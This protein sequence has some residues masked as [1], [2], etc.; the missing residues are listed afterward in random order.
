MRMKD[1]S[2]PERVF[3]LSGV[4]DGN[5]RTFILQDGSNSVGR[6]PTSSILL[7]S[8]SVSHRHAIVHL[9]EGRITVRDLA[10]KNGTIVN[11]RPV[12]DAELREGDGI[13]FGSID[14]R[15]E[16]MDP[17]DTWLG[18]TSPPRV[19]VPAESPDPARTST[20]VLGGDRSELAVLRWVR[21]LEE[22]VEH[23]AL[24]SE[25]NL[26]SGLGHLTRA[27][28]ATGAALLEIIPGSASLCRAGYGS[29]SIELSAADL[30]ELA[31]EA[32]LSGGVLTRGCGRE[33]AKGTIFLASRSPGFVAV[34]FEG[35]LAPNADTRSVLGTALGLLGLCLPRG[36]SKT[37]T[38]S[39]PAEGLLF[40][41]DYVRG[42]SAAITTIYRQLESVVKSDLPILLLGETGV[43][44]ECLAGVVHSSSDRRRGPFLPVNCAAIP[45]D[46]LEA[47]L[48]GIRAGVATGVSERKGKFALADGG[49]LFLDEIGD[50][51]APLQ[52]K[53]LRAL[54][55]HVIV[56][57][58]GEEQSVDVRIVAATN[59]DIE[60]RVRDGRFR[61]DLYYRLAGLV[62]KVP[63]LRQR[64]EDIP[65]LTEYFFRQSCED[66]GKAIPGITYAAVRLLT[67]MRWPGNVRELRHRLRRLV[68]LAPE[69]CPIDTALLNRVGGDD[70]EPGPDE[71]R[72]SSGRDLS[73]WHD[74]DLSRLERRVVKEA[75]RRVGG[76]RTH[77]ARLLGISRSALRRRLGQYDL[78]QESG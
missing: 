46:L 65:A 41:E 14:L 30:D 19:T 12:P 59:T 34:I 40:P 35:L 25:P 22:L 78:E 47:E 62:L 64:T 20:L 3:A 56:P 32:E 28:G 37:G 48:F 4:V 42:H 50:M 39:E 75:L 69:G 63:P 17:E 53:L 74:L 1:S 57:V 18:I 52:A 33:G 38:G 68:Y 31:R 61:R 11:G 71:T 8:T 16:E 72:D 67:Q 5:P 60:S 66:A 2:F 27:V 51:S 21:L 44:K 49:T 15:V 24:G 13:R 6:L 9:R 58:G 45:S 7:G 77:A 73:L 43:G 55:G 54:E 36:D 29:V 76:N 26:E 23:L 10:S 70:L